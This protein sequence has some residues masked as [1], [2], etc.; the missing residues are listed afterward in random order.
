MIEILPEMIGF[1]GVVITLF[2]NAWL[3]RRAEKEQQK[4]ERRSLR[5][6]LI[7]ELKFTDEIILSKTIEGLVE[8]LKD[9]PQSDGLL[10]VDT[11]NHIYTCNGTRIGLLSEMEAETVVGAYSRLQGRSWYLRAKY[12]P[13]PR[14]NGYVVIPSE[15]LKDEL[16][17]EEKLRKFI[18]KATDALEKAR[19]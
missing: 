16:E 14:S 18:E 6:A 11:L 12:D 4:H 8:G 5:S 1:G 19:E 15:D 17:K 9:H 13:S 7:A 10:P 2:L 3:G